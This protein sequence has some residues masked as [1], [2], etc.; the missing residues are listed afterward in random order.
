MIHRMSLIAAAAL[1][2]S[3]CAGAQLD[4]QAGALNNEMAFGQAAAFSQAAQ[5]RGGLPEAL[6]NVST[7]FRA[8]VPTTINFEFNKATLDAAARATLDQQA[9]WISGYPQVQFSVYG[10]T[11]L[12]G[13][14]GYNRS[15]GM[16]RAQATVAYLVSRGVARGQLKAV[17]S[18]GETQPIVTT[19]SPERLNRRTL[20]DVSG[21]ANLRKTR[22]TGTDGKRAL[23]VYGEYVDDAGS[24]ITADEGQ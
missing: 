12:V 15:L 22:G 23:I 2:I 17:A 7:S 20:T 18:R 6:R 21:F 11:D 5:I 10:H 19:Q 1:M 14:A 13:S 24:E 4:R 3:G 8:A 16:R 9:R